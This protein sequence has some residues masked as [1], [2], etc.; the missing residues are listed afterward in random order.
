MYLSI[1]PD[2]TIRKKPFSFR[3]KTF[4]AALTCSV[5]SGCCGNFPTVPPLRNLRSSTPSMLPSVNRPSSLLVAGASASD[6]IS[7]AVVATV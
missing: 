2:S 5:R 7:A 6:V 3:D 1:N 4:K